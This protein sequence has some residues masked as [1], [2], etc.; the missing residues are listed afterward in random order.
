M[1]KASQLLQSGKTKLVGLLDQ[2]ALHSHRKTVE[3]KVA[4]VRAM[5]SE[6]DAAQAQ[7]T[8][9]FDNKNGK[10]KKGKR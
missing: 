2:G 3:K 10:K 5:I 6:L 9:M 4:N 1:E 8:E 7:V